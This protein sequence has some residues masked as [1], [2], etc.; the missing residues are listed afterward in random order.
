MLLTAD[1]MKAA[2]EKADVN[3]LRLALYQATG[4]EELARMNVDW[5]ALRGGVF[6]WGS[7]SDEDRDAVRAKALA[8][9][10]EPSNHGPRDDVPDDAEMRRLMEL[11]QGRALTD[12]EFGAYRGE[13][14]LEEFPRDPQWRMAPAAETLAKFK[15]LIVGAGASGIAM[16]IKLSRLG[17][18]HTILERL[19]DLSGTWHR[20]RYPNVRVDT[21][22]LV[23]QY[24]FEKRYIFDEFFPT[25]AAI[26]DYMGAVAAKYGVDEHVVF[27]QE[28]VD[29]TWD[30]ATSTWRVAASNSRGERSSYEANV[31]ITATGLFSTPKMP[32]F[33]GLETF[34]GSIVHTANW[35]ESLQC[36]G[37]RL[38]VIGNGSTGTQLLPKLAE[39]A[40][41]V[42]AFQRTPGWIV[43]VSGLRGKVKDHTRWLLET[44]PFYW[45]WASYGQFVATLA[46]QEAQIVD[47]AWQARGGRISETNDALRE[48]LTDY[49]KQKVGSDP[50]LVAKLVPDYA[51]LAR[52]IVVDSG[53]Y[54]ALMRDNVNLNT[55][56]V[57]E[58]VPEG[59]ITRTGELIE[60]DAIIA[61]AG[62]EVSRYYYPAEFHGRDGVTFEELWSKDGARAYLGIS[63]PGF[64]NFY[65]VYGPNSQGRGGGGFLMYVDL[66]TQYVAEMLVAQIE[67][68]YR[69]VEV[70]RP[71]FETYNE[72]IDDAVRELIYEEEGKGGY[73]LN[74]HGRSGVQ[75]PWTVDEYHARLLPADIAD[76]DV[77]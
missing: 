50:D 16:S 30:D 5:I 61:A 33:P 63:V 6:Q 67:G 35:D 28:V 7:L 54:D 72:E 44:M 15:V 13:V 75:M 8:F 40:D 64:P 11:F 27:D 60:V 42:T 34:T 62:F 20:Q 76:Y 12:K 14:A 1:L 51:P 29:A 39:T 70:K 68:G 52:R 46:M 66:W 69:E 53:W 36:D 58:V 57:R 74:E 49:I 25:Q 23:Y 38:A 43:E 32:D 10:S 48:I 55:D 22:F 3:A 37:K 65:S 41:H 4:D 59:I 26:K 77:K 47:R 19:D 73:F 31:L 18:R 17:I 71:V 24:K 45:N 9:L 2:V 56:G 21:N